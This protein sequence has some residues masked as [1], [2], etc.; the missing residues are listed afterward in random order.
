MW[1]NWLLVFLGGGLGSLFRFLIGAYIPKTMWNSI[2]LGTL[3][4]NLLGSLIL[5]FIIGVS[6][7]N[8]FSESNWYT[9]ATIGFCGGFTT[10]STFAYE[11]GVLIQNGDFLSTAVYVSASLIGGLMAVFAGLWL[12]RLV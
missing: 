10:F 3:T 2:P 7:R 6:A 9:F 12:S 1:T 4:V 8:S 11:N 5:G